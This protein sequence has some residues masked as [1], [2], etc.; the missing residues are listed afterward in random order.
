MARAL[1]VGTVLAVVSVACSAD[2]ECIEATEYQ[3]ALCQ[4]KLPK[5]TSVTIQENAATSPAS[6]DRKIDCSS[7]KL[8]AKDVRRYFENA[9]KT[10]PED[11]HHT[12]DWSPCYASGTLVFSDGRKA[13]WSINQF[14]TGSLS[15][16]GESRMFLY[17]PDC[18]Y[19][20][21]E[22]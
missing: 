17:C 20:P 7:F 14:R 1:M 16:T 21:F 19:K 15:I 8:T 13:H 11:A 2:E 12:L 5:T 18:K 9:L 3:P 4:V 22:W 6:D 10:S